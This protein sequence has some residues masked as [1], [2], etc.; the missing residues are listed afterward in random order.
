MKVIVNTYLNV[1]VGSPSLNAPC[2]QYLAPGSELT[3]EE[4][5]Y[6]GDEYEGSNEWLRDEAGNYYWKGGVESLR[7]PANSD[8][9]F[10]LLGIQEIWETYGEKGNLAKVLVLD[11]GLNHKLS[12]FKNAVNLDDSFSIVK[13]NKQIEDPFG[14]GTHCAGL[15]AARSKTI[16]VGVAPESTLLIGQVTLSDSFDNDTPLVDAL[17]H[18]LDK[19]FDIVSMSLQLTESKLQSND[20][21]QIIDKLITERN[22]IVI[23][24]IGNDT[25]GK[26]REFK[27]YPGFFRRCISVGACESDLSLSKYS[28]YPNWPTIYCY[29]SNIPSFKQKKDPEPLT[30]TSQATAIVAGLIALIISFLKKNSI[31]YDQ[32]S[33]R[34]LLTSYAMPLK[35]QTSK[36]AIDPQKIFT[37]LSKFKNDGIINLQEGITQDLGDANN[38]GGIS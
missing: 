28:L 21:K 14:H 23:A 31:Q 35:D 30:G 10:D 15:I 9:W 17:H 12:P 22:K 36:G 32:E 19:D 24:S 7:V 6:K 20:L 33:I 34:L 26:N 25:K 37:K 18:F 3:V 11:S 16:N 5:H 27:R 29:G 1:R 13:K 2:Y 8:E 38:T 4:T